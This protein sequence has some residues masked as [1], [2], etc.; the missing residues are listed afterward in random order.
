MEYLTYLYLAICYISGS[1]AYRYFKIRQTSSNV[2]SLENRYLL[3]LIYGY[4]LIF[5][6]IMLLKNYRVFESLLYHSIGIFLG[7]CIAD[8]VISEHKAKLSWSLLFLFMALGMVSCI[9]LN[10]YKLKN[11]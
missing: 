4:T 7:I 5:P 10:P 6:F 2:T 8:Y 3:Y 9:F 1:T 11:G